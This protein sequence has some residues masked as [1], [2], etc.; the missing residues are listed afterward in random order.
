MSTR[1]YRL[2]VSSIIATADN[3]TS[4][5]ISKNGKVNALC[6]TCGQT[7][8][9]DI[10]SYQRFELSKQSSSS[11]ALND[12]PNSI[13]CHFTTGGQAVASQGMAQNI[14]VAGLSWEVTNGDIIYLHELIAGTAPVAGTVSVDIYVME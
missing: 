3:K 4:L 9:A 7:S 1:V 13:L 11:F 12:A 5:K 14:F 8:A 10:T 6:I 2:Y